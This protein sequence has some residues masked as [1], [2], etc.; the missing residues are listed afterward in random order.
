MPADSQFACLPRYF[1]VKAHG[2][3]TGEYLS[4]CAG[5]TPENPL[6]G[7]ENEAQALGVGVQAAMQALAASSNIPSLDEATR[8]GD[9][10]AASQEYQVQQLQRELLLRLGDVAQ[11]LEDKLHAGGIRTEAL[12]AFVQ[13]HEAIKASGGAPGKLQPGLAK[14]EPNPTGRRMKAVQM[15]ASDIMDTLKFRMLAVG[16]FR[17]LGNKKRQSRVA[18]RL[19]AL[20]ALVRVSYR[21]TMAHARSLIL[22]DCFYCL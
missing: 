7:A 8:R 19:F 20:G 2:C 6:Q 18:F 10:S 11:V 1:C 13:D 16:L 4:Q 5:S 3:V 12:R 22:L 21:A 14:T 15:T 9:A 17:G